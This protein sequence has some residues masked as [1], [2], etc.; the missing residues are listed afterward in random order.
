MTDCID[1]GV[2]CGGTGASQ[3]PS[4]CYYLTPGWTICKTCNKIR[5]QQNEYMCKYG[6]LFI[7]AFGFSVTLMAVGLSSINKS[8]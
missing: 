1:C 2:R 3:N 4:L 8:R 7:I 5:I 6:P